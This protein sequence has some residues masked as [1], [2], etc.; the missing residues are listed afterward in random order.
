M[1]MP[2][3]RPNGDYANDRKW[4]DQY[5]DAAARILGPK[6]IIPAPIEKDVRE[7]TDLIILKA[8]DMRIA[9]RMRSPWNKDRQ[10][11]E[12]YYYDFTVRTHRD[13]G[14]KTELAKLSEGYGDWMFYGHADPD[15][16][17][18][19]SQWMII[20]LHSWRAQLCRCG[21]NKKITP[22]GDPD[23]RENRG[24]GTYFVAFDVREFYPTPQIL[25]DASHLDKNCVGIRAAS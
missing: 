1:S 10:P 25:I 23:Y 2:L 21:L 9:M 19:I 5:I 12:R 24:D 20:N 6:L 16:A 14:K 4:S 13:S 3:N 7:S 17:G 8:R 18:V 11:P 22:P 15:I